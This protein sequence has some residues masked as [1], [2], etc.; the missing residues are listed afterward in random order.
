MPRLESPRPR[1]SKGT[2]QVSD[3]GKKVQ[4]NPAI[5][6]WEEAQIDS[7][8]RGGPADPALQFRWK[9]AAGYYSVGVLHNSENKSGRRILANAAPLHEETSWPSTKSLCPCTSTMLIA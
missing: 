9:E 2:D 7:G 6:L 5:N 1:R 8:K 3:S 4:P